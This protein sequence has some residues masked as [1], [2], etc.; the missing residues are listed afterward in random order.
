MQRCGC[1]KP[2]RCERKKNEGRNSNL[3]RSRRAAPGKAAS[4]NEKISPSVKTELQG[5]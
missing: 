5:I 3:G 1:L 4:V 2:E